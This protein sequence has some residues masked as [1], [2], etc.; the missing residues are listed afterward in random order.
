MTGVQGSGDDAAGKV[1]PGEILLAPEPVVLDDGPESLLE[2]LNTG[3]RPIQVG[4]H[5]HFFEANS[6]LRFD[7][8]ASYGCR[9]A[10]AAGTSVRFEPGISRTVAVVALRGR[11]RVEGLRGLVAGA[12]DAPTSGR[13]ASIE[14]VD[15][16][17]VTG[18]AS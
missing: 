7:R 4:S 13:D 2:V 1:V 10:V 9:L 6:A 15:A 14:D 11:R 3:D 17:T 16:R 18:D 5:F 12:L 8:P